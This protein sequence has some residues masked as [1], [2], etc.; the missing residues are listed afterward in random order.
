MI[1]NNSKIVYYYQTFV[2]L[3]NLLKN[4]CKTITD[5]NISSIHFGK[6]TNNYLSF[7]ISNSFILTSAS[8]LSFLKKN[9]GLTV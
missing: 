3:D 5:L 9:V 2:G 6:N 1:N 7:T 4:N 8:S